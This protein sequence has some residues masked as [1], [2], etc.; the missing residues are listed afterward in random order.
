MIPLKIIIAKQN[1]R[2]G[3]VIGA[4]DIRHG[5]IKVITQ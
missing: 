3:F 5:W 4:E 1:S 2:A